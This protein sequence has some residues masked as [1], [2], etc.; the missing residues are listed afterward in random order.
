MNIREAVR[1]VNA[2]S[3]EKIRRVAKNHPAYKPGRCHVHGTI[4][5]PEDIIKWAEQLKK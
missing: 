1:I 3:G 4:W 2:R 5:G